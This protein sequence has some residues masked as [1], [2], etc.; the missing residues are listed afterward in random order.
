M[1]AISRSDAGDQAHSI[2]SRCIAIPS[3]VTRAAIARPAVY[4]ATKRLLAGSLVPLTIAPFAAGLYEFETNNVGVT[5][6]TKRV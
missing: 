3:I 5:E 4:W 1:L 2:V 6:A